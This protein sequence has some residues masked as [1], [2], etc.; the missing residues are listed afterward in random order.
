MPK[1]A[2]TSV[3][4]KSSQ[5]IYV[6]GKEPLEGFRKAIGTVWKN[7]S[8]LYHLNDGK[9]Y[10]QPQSIFASGDDIYVAGEYGD[11]ALVW[12]NGQVLWRLSAGGERPE[13]NSIFILDGDVYVAGRDSFSQ[14]KA[15]VR[16][17]VAVIWK[18]GQV[19]YRLSEGKDVQSSVA[20]SIFVSGGDIYGAGWI[21]S[22]KLGHQAMLW[23]NDPVGWRSDPGKTPSASF[24]FVSNEDVFVAG[25]E[26]ID[27]SAEVAT[28]WKNG[29][30]HKRLRSAGK[31][32]VFPTGLAVSD[33]VVYVSGWECSGKRKASPAFLWKCS[34]EDPK[35]DII[36]DKFNGTL[37]SVFISGEDVYLVGAEKDAKLN[38]S[39]PSVW[40]NGQIHHRLS[41]SENADRVKPTCIYVM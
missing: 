28:L 6:A 3:G 22:P 1:Q 5:D 38:T 7:G 8:V 4:Q 32:P 27:N 23:K 26:S 36:E 10:C 18:N 40:K 41:S 37:N 9:D 13:A 21:A 20:Q 11:A 24:V 12:K 35:A 29:A 19:L 39:A 30:V 14:P 16:K 34:A 25:Y 17:S 31:H 2:T 15:K 33:G